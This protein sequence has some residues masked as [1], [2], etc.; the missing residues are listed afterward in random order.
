MGMPSS[1]N[2]LFNIH[3]TIQLHFHLTPPWASCISLLTPRSQPP[4]IFTIP[5]KMSTNFTYLQIMRLAGS[6]QNLIFH[7]EYQ[8]TEIAKGLLTSPHTWSGTERN[9]SRSGSHS[10]FFGS[11][12]DLDPFLESWNGS[13][14]DL[15]IQEKNQ[16]S[17]SLREKKLLPWKFLFQNPFRLK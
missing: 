15:F 9:S 7:F 3:H 4:N 13:G 17:S 5:C 1:C 14:M 2:P 6:T 12:M 10:T 16:F 11:W 8:I